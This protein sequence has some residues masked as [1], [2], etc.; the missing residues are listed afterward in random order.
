MFAQLRNWFA[1][2]KQGVA[3]EHAGASHIGRVRT[4][5]Q[6]TIEM[7]PEHG[8]FIVCDGLGGHA[9][10]K[11]ASAIACSAVRDGV[12]AGDG[13]TVA[14]QKA[15]QEIVAMGQTVDRE[16]RQPG[17]TVVALRLTAATWEVA[18][19]GDSRCWLFPAHGHVRQL[20]VD[21]TVVQQMVNWGDITPEEAQNHPERNKL[22]Q[23]LGMVR[24][25]VVVGSETGA[26]VRGMSFLL[27]SDGLA[28]WNS[29]ERFQS[30]VV[31]KEPQAAVDQ[32]VEESLQAGGRDNISCIVVK[33]QRKEKG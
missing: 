13:L 8:L 30:I 16:Q 11:Q 29:P 31:K 5:N 4:A 17:S 22:S 25:K 19:V 6:D 18:W 27:A 20:T 24:E 7:L 3:V 21:H 1:I 10:G 28:Y 12:I 26:L 2:K 32:L 33:T 14:V 9:G 15:H 23:S